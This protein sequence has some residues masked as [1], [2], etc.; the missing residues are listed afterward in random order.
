MTTQK[1]ALGGTAVC[2]R[3]A[4]AARAAAPRAVAVQASKVK[5]VGWRG[6]GGV[7][8]GRP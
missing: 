6:G 2:A 7:C 3:P 1:A 4:R 8:R 5:K